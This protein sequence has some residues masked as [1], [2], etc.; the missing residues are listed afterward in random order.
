VKHFG[1]RGHKGASCAILGRRA[2]SHLA[3]RVDDDEAN[4]DEANSEAA[5]W[6]GS[7]DMLVQVHGVVHP[8]RVYG[9]DI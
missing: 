1:S 2:G 6:T 9:Q 3:K 4:S 5:P 7:G 8:R